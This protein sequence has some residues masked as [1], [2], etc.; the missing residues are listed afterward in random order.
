MSDK[1][2]LLKYNSVSV[3]VDYEIKIDNQDVVYVLK[4]GKPITIPAISGKD[5]HDLVPDIS[6]DD[7]IHDFESSKGSMSPT[8][9]LSGI[10]S[11]FK[12]I[13]GSFRPGGKSKL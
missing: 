9:K 5:V 1:V 10:K 6:F 12:N 11:G 4:D 7:V 3:P 13:I 2:E 8:S